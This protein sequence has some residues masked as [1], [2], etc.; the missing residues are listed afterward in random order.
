MFLVK[1][2]CFK[3]S[4]RDISHTKVIKQY[5]MIDMIDDYRNSFEL[6]LMGYKCL[7]TGDK[8]NKEQNQA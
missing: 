2:S 6:S 1:N 3:Q 7:G 5:P 4:K 8:N